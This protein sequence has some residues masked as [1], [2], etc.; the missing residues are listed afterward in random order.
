[1]VWAVTVVQGREKG[2]EGVVKSFGRKARNEYNSEHAAQARQINE[3]NSNPFE[4]ARTF[5]AFRILP[6]SA[7]RG[8]P[9]MAICTCF[10]GEKYK[11]HSVRS[12]EDSPA[13]IAS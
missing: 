8:L 2:D 6:K 7:A 11:I 12:H 9:F 3:R 1:M 10:V 5:L 4:S 13:R